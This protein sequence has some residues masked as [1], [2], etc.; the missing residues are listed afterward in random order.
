MTSYG[1]RRRIAF[2]LVLSLLVTVGV[3]ACQRGETQMRQDDDVLATP[4]HPVT[5]PSGRYALEVLSGRVTTG[6]P[7]G[8]V[9][10]ARFRISEVGGK[11]LYEDDTDYTLLHTTFFL[12]ADDTDQAWVY[13]GDVGTTYLERDATGAWT[14]HDFLPDSRTDPPT[15][16]K[17]ARPAFFDR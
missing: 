9:M 11:V 5:S 13:S 12:W 2:A 7:Q 3:S 15:F 10:V 8:S 16:L 17:Q 14:K 4:D 1:P 6:A